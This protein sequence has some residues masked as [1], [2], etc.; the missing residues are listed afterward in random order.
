[1]I[2]LD[3][4]DLNIKFGQ[5]SSIYHFAARIGDK[6]IFNLLIEKLGN[7]LLDAK[8]NHGITPLRVGAENGHLDIV[9]L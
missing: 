2:G 5:G 6:D 1:M 3:N 7:E 9:N 4:I 8:N